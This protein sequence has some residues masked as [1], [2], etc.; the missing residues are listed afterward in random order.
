[1]EKKEA[2]RRELAE[3]PVKSDII[4]DG[5]IIRVEKDV[6]LLPNGKETVR[7]IVRHPGA[8]AVVAARAEEF[9]F[10]RQ[11][12]YALAEI[13]LEIPAGKLEPGE[14][15]AL[16]ARRELREETGYDAE[17]DFWGMYYSS[18]GFSDEKIYVYGARDLTWA[19]L[20][21]DDDEFLR[22]VRLS[23]AETFARLRQGEFRDA[24]T[25]LG[26]LLSQA[27]AL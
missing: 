25:V 8:V 11:Y 18:P 19:P 2:E 13:T 14:E 22:V 1:M 15:P 6:A 23:R 24:K 5:R 26:L 9:I 12:R 21:A 7:E 4:F 10:V 27:H 17:L 3:T 20:V 16:C